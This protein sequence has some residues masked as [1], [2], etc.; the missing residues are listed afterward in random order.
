MRDNNTPAVEMKSVSKSFQTKGAATLA[1][2]HVTLDVAAG[3]I[4]TLIGPSGSG[5][6]TCLRTINGLETISSGEIRVFGKP[7]GRSKDAFLV[8]RDTAMIFQRFELFPHLNAL[9]NIALA[10]RVR[11]GKSK[12]E[13]FETAHALLK[14]VGLEAH[15]SKFPRMLSGGQQ[16]RVAIARA[17]AVQPRILLCDEPTSALDPELV[18]DVL[19]LLKTVASTG[20]TMVIVT[21]EMR[22]ARDVSKK[23]YFFDAGRIV[24]TGPTDA[25]LGHPQSPRLRTFLA[26]LHR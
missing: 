6:S 13:A 14:K 22:F 10:P 1:L 9:E 11:L 25:L 21:H 12:E 18:D 3:D 24:E 23:C 15:G 8:R 19:E 16:Q 7:Y 20:M 2:D 26:S 5:K 17:L 4:V